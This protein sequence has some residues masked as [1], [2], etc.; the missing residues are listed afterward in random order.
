MHGLRARAIPVA[1]AMAAMALFTFGALPA[2]AQDRLALYKSQYASEKDP[3]RKA[4]LLEKIS[5]PEFETI[6][7][8]VLNGNLEEG[9]NALQTF[10]EDCA[11]THRSLKA[12]GNDPDQ[13]PAGFKELQISVRQT[14]NRLGEL[15]AGLPKDDQKPF[16]KVRGQLEEL[17][18]E[19]IRE[20][21]PRQG[22]PG[23][24]TNSK[25]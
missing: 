2:R 8:Q 10:K 18:S 22:K 23:V 21:F 16:L 11:E 6:R 3:V 24:P 25:P 13:K 19:L 5:A 20:L 17:D 1:A 7:Q 15:L 12:K 4:K 9:V 14:L